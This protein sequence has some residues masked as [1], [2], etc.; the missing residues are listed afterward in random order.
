M[1]LDGSDT[2][3]LNGRLAGLRH[4]AAAD[5]LRLRTP[6]VGRP[7]GQRG[8][9]DE[10]ACTPGSVN[11]RLAA[12]RWAT[13]HLGLPSPAGS[14][15][16]PAGSGGQP[17]N[18]C[19]GTRRP[20]LTL[21]RV[22]FTEPSRSPG[23]LVVSYTTVSPL[24]PEPKP[25]GGLFSVA[26]SRGSPRVAVSNHPALWSPDVPRARSLPHAAAR[27]ARPPYRSS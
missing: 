10:S 6:S 22:G 2:W 16:L 11:A 27:P 8:T 26:L 3:G 15:G 9:A 17:S 1:L 23:M 18:A 13:I 7:A 14:S 5:Y 24:P 12:L 25:D 19:A 21:L 4:R 20:L